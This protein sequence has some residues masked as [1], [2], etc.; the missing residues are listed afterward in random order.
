MT[1][2]KRSKP[3]PRKNPAARSR[4]LSWGRATP[5]ARSFLLRRRRATGVARPQQSHPD[6][7]S[8]ESLGRRPADH[9]HEAVHIFADLG[10]VVRRI[11]VLVHVER[12]QRHATGRR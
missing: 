2:W 5:V 11:G 7:L 8:I 12:E 1:T 9:R 10:A 4:A 3:R 6:S